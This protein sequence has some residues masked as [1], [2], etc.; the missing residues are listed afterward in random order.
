MLNSLSN[1]VLFGTKEAYNAPLNAFITDNRIRLRRHTPTFP[2]AHALHPYRT[3]T[4]PLPHPYSTLLHPYPTL[5]HHYSTLLHP[6][7]TLFHP[8]LP[9][10]S[11]RTLP[12]SATSPPCYIP[13]T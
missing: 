10:F 9:S 2:H 6:Y 1:N 12:R 11:A 4:P 3:P 13:A 5:L 7:S 8:V